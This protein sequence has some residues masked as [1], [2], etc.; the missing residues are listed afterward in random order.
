MEQE[1]IDQLI[2][3]EIFDDYELQIDMEERCERHLRENG[4]IPL[5]KRS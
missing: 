1:E 5:I 4:Y 3:E 2:R